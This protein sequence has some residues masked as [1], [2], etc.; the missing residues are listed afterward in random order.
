M[1][2]ELRLENA[3]PE[4]TQD[5]AQSFRRLLE[6][7]EANRRTSLIQTF[8]LE[9]LGRVLRLDPSRIDPLATFASL[10]VDSLTSLELRNRLQT[11]LG[12]DLQATLLFTYPTI[13]KLVVHIV[14]KLAFDNPPAPTAPQTTSLPQEKAAQAEPSAD[15]E[16]DDLLALL[17]EELTATKK[18]G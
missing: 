7:T 17:D 16:V 4:A 13:D 8:A 10:G 18:R 9:Q 14:G 1:L 6:S 5:G 15:M 12:L 3:N 2:A 11:S